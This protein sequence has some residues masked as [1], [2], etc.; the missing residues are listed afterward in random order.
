MLPIFESNLHAIV[1]APLLFVVAILV[2]TVLGWY[3]GHYRL[4]KQSEGGIAV[5]DPLVAAIFGLS[6]LVLG[7]AFSGSA[8]RN[9]MQMGEIRTQ[10]QVL[11]KVYGSLQYL[12]PSDQ[13]TVK[14]SLDN[15][16]DTRLAA[17]QNIKGMADIDLEAEKI[18]AVT[19][20]IQE[21]VI[22]AIPNAP[23]RNQALIAELLSPQVK[24]LST[25]FAAGII[26]MKSHPSTLVMRFLFG[27]LC[28]AA[29]L[30]GYTMAVKRESDWLLAILYT[31][32]I[33]VALYVILSL[34]LPNL[35]M[36]Y[37]E[38]NRDFLVLKDKVK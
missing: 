27:L 25:I 20:K 21:Q 33:G 4:N 14:K 22:L 17:Y 9:S 2:F 32:L 10:A 1:F 28:V 36:P 13:L 6:A 16:L 30:I 18:L 19:R 7:F 3:F 29:F 23:A 31:A 8:S 35:F 15:L 24:E 5:R 34:E 38:L 37:E 12:A 26:N 11:Y